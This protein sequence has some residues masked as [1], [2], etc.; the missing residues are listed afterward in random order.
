VSNWDEVIKHLSRHADGSIAALVLS[1][2]G[3]GEGGIATSNPFSHLS[4]VNLSPRHAAVIKAKLKPNAPILLLGCHTATSDNLIRMAR[5]LNRKVI[6]NTG[7]VDTD[8]H[9][10]GMWIEFPP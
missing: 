2:H 5:M 4:Y 10:E 3:S 1:G 6:G 9:G 8:N 7:A